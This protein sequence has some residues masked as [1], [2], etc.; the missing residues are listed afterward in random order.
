MTFDEWWASKDRPHAPG[1][2]D[3]AWSA[4]NAALSV[5]A[6]QSTNPINDSK[7]PET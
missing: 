7:E 3:L 4:W 5:S 1:A 2:R 6:S